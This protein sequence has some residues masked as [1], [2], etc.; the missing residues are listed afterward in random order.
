MGVVS[1]GVSFVCSGRDPRALAVSERIGTLTTIGAGY[2]IQ[3]VA[4]LALLWVP[5]REALLGWRSGAALGPA[6]DGFL[7]ALTGS[8]AIPFGAAPLAVLVELGTPR[9]GHVATQDEGPLKGAIERTYA[10][11]S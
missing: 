7:Y 6:A 5:S 3:A 1:P 2:A 9:A 10:M 11:V 8:Y 4:L